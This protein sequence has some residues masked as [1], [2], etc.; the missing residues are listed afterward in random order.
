MAVCSN[1]QLVGGDAADSDLSLAPRSSRESRTPKILP[2][3]GMSWCD[4]QLFLTQT[5]T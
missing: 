4:A 5:E 1:I 3:L 2:A